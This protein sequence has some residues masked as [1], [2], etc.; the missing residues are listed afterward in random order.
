SPRRRGGGSA[1]PAALTVFRAAYGFGPARAAP[2]PFGAI[3]RSSAR[4]CGRWAMRLRVVAVLAVVLAAAC[5][6]AAETG[7]DG[8]CCFGEP[9]APWHGGERYEQVGENPFVSTD[10]D[11]VATFGVDVDTA[12][13][14]LM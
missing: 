11:A 4:S 2:A 5:S 12:S 13:Y 3:L 14:A 9:L 10:V 1:A 6:D 7:L 8:G